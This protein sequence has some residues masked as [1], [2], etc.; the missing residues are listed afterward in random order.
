MPLTDGQEAASKTKARWGSGGGGVGEVKGGGSRLLELPSCGIVHV[1][2]PG[3]FNLR[4]VFH[5]VVVRFIR[6]TVASRRVRLRP[7]PA[8]DSQAYQQG[9][10]LHMTSRL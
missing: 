6:R 1:H 9:A 3:E 4:M 7:S 5:S 8:Y 2:A 10:L